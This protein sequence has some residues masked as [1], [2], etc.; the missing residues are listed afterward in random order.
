MEW[1]RP[2][3]TPKADF[4]PKKV[5]LCMWW[6]WKGVLYYELLLE[7]QMINSNKHCSQLDQLKA[8]LYEKCLESVNRE[9]I[10]FCEDNARPHISLITT[11]NCSAWM[12]SSDSSTVF[13]RH[14]TFR[15][16]FGLY[17]ILLMEKFQFPE[18][19]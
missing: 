2:L 18:K 1:K 6:D 19:L 8:V 5:M 9:H 3:T 10:I 16:P 15:C 11:Q 12:G 13:T 7:N 14:C 17:K 4:H